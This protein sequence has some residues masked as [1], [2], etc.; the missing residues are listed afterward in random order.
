MARAKSDTQQFDVLVNSVAPNRSPFFNSAP[1]TT[2]LTG[3]NYQYQPDVVDPEEDTLTY[4]LRQQPEGMQIDAET[5]LVTWQSDLI[6]LGEYSV[7]VAVEDGVG[8]TTLQ[9]F[10]LTASDEPILDTQAPEIELVSNGNLVNKGESVTLQVRATDDRDLASLSLEIDGTSLILTPN[11]LANGQLYTATTQLD[12][13]GVY[14]VVAEATDSA[15]NVTTEEIGLRVLDPSDTSD[16]EVILDISGIQVGT[17]ISEPFDILGSVNDE[18]LASYRVEYAQKSLLNLDSLLEENSA[19]VLLNESR[20]AV[21]GVLATLDPRFL[22][23]DQY[24]IR[25]TAFDVNGAGTVRGFEIGVL[26]ENKVGNFTLDATDLSLPLTGIPINVQ[27]RYDTL[28]ANSSASFGYG[29]EFAGLDARITES[30]PQEPEGLEGILFANKGFRFGDRVTLTTPD[31]KRVGF[32]FKPEAAIAGF[33]GTAFRP[34][35]VP[36]PG[37]EETLTVEDIYLSQKSDG[38]FGLYLFSFGYNPS[39]YQ[40]TTK[41]NLTYTYNQ[42]DGLQTVE[43][44]NGNVLTYSA[45]GITSSTGETVRFERD[46]EDRITTITDPAGNRIRYEYDTNGDLVA[47]TDR[48]GNTTR[49]EYDSDQPHYLTEEIDPLGRSSVRTEFDDFGRIERI[50]DAEGNALEI[51]IDFDGPTDTQTI[52]DALGLKTTLI[53]DDR[54]NVLQQVDPEGGVTQ[55]EYDDDNR[56]KVLTDARGFETS[57]SYDDRGNLLTETNALNE[58]TTYTYNEL[59]QVETITDARGFVSTNRYDNVGNLIEREDAEGNITKYDYYA[60]GTLKTVV[61]AENNTTDYVYDEAGRVEKLEDATGATT[62][63]DY[64]NAGNLKTIETLLG[65]RTSFAYDGAG[66]LVRIVDA[67]GNDTRIQYNSVG[68]RTAVIDALGR[69]TSYTYNKRGSLEKTTYADG[70]SETNVYD[71]NDQQ[72]ASIDRAGRTKK[73]IYDGLGRLVSTIYPD[74]T[75][76]DDSD[77]P[78]VHREYDKTGNLTAFVDENGN[79]TEYEYDKAGQQ[80]L[81]R[82]VLN[83]E[84]GYDY[85]SV[86]NLIAVT[87]ALNR[88][89]KYDYDKVGQLTKTTFADNTSTQTVYDTL[90][91]IAKEIDQNEIGTNFSYDELDRLVQVE[92]AL[93][94]KT[95][96]DYDN[97]GNLISQTDA[98]GRVTKYKYDELDQRIETELPLGQTETYTYDAVGNVKSATD[99]N[100]QTID[101][102]YNSNDL[103]ESEN[104]EDGSSITYGYTAS[105]KLETVTDIRGETEY[106][107]DERDRLITQTNPDDTFL[108]YSYDDVGNRISLA[109]PSGQVAY[110]YDQLNRIKTVN[111]RNDGTTTYSY[112]SVG[113]LF[114]TQLPNGV[115]EARDYNA[116]DNLTL[117]EQRNA[118]GLIA[119]YQYT[120]GKTGRQKKVEELSG[121]IAEYS[122]DALYRLIEETV[123]DPIN[124]NRTFSYTYDDVGNRLTRDDSAEGLTAYQYDNNNRLRSSNINGVATTYSYDDNGNT[125]TK[126]GNQGTTD[127]TWNQQNRLIQVEMPNGDII[128]YQYDGNGSRVAEIVNGIETRFLVDSGEEFSQIIEEYLL[129][130]PLIL[131]TPLATL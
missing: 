66:R 76:G 13:S 122:Y 1:V 114:Q 91:R 70:T 18:N 77:N 128:V 95:I 3:E 131:S 126:N 121:R 84:T 99:F 16:P 25:V 59:N 75:P 17:T 52:S 111:D 10:Q 44:L 26:T 7:V 118:D 109:T 8:N 45:D 37:V 32:T 96:Y 56:V 73:F 46:S 103:L 31:G 93:G 9:T 38:T 130:V 71:A 124:G 14:S 47:V 53:Y 63:F 39:E 58:K 127:Y 123:T 87:D 80:I 107:Y 33:L 29:W 35:F 86:G 4:S 20:V 40:L 15:G 92:D 11:T 61:D 100:K 21:D 5:G 6:S 28:Q 23:N 51:D 27:R 90:G 116:V 120:L 69:R 101:Y 67:K 108:T 49:Y 41:N 54:G 79:R 48:A 102:A 82:D 129:M 64:D 119:S 117:L 112:N 78:R 50:I 83:N 97:E 19:Y 42:F 60:D 57:F 98:L 94:N 104:F 2:V 105:L 72:I 24:M 89:T 34:V 110:T 12:A 74:A 106:N 81:I 68:E 125:L 62:D 115:V 113:N 55:Y 30:A 85:D 22:V 88:Q 65:N 36:D 43:D